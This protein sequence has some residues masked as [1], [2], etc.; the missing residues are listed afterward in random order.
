MTLEPREVTKKEEPTKEEPRPALPPPPKPSEYFPGYEAEKVGIG[1]GLYAAEKRVRQAFTSMEKVNLA[2]TPSPLTPQPTNPILRFL[3]GT[4]E[5]WMVSAAGGLINIEELEQRKVEAQAELDASTRELESLEW[6]L[7]VLNTLPGYLANQ[8]YTIT[9]ADDVL[10]LVANSTLS[11]VDR[12]WLERTLEKLEHLNNILPEDFTGTVDEAQEKVLNEI[13]SE[14]KLELRAVHN[15]T[16]DELERSFQP[17]AVDMPEGMTAEQVREVMGRIGL[18]E[19]LQKELDVYLRERASAW[20]KETDR[21]NLLRAGLLQPESPDLT[22][23]EFANLVFVQ[24]VMAGIEILDK[25]FDMLPRPLAASAIIGVHNMFKTDEDT[26]AG[27]MHETYQY[28]RSQ[29]ESSWDAYALALNDTE[30]NWVMRLG[31]ETVFDPTTY[32]GIGIAT[33]G[34][35]MVGRGLTRLGMRTAG[36]RIGPFVGAIENGFVEGSDALF[37]AGV[38]AVLSPIKGSFWLAGAG[39]QIPRTMT[40]LSRNFGRQASMNFKAVLDR[41]FPSVRN[42]KGLASGDIRDTAEA[43]IK[44]ALDRPAEGHDLMVKTGAELLEFGYLDANTAGKLLKGLVDETFDFDVIRL[45]RINNEVLNMFSGQSPKA[46]AG[47]I[48]SQMGLLQTDEALETTVTKLAVLKDSIVDGAMRAFKADAPNSQLIGMFDNLVNTRYENLASP[49]TTHMT[50]AGR[51]VSWVSRVADRVLHASQLISLERKVIMPFARWNLLFANFGPFNYLENMQRSFLGGAEV[52]YPKSYGGVAQTNRLFKGLTNAPYELQMAE[53]GVQRME[54]ALIDPKT[55]STAAFRNGR[56][57]F[58]TKS[59]KFRGKDIGKGI[60][61][62]GQEFK[63]TDMQAYND[64]WEQLTTIQRA[65]DYQ[66]HYM[67]SLQ[68]VAPDEMQD[69]A[70]SVLRRRAEIEQIGKFSP[71]DIKDIERSLIQDATVGPEEVAAHANLSTLE[72]E[73]R[74]ISKE[75]YKTLD[76]CTDVHRVTKA[77]I[78][79]EVLDGSIFTDI[80]GR[81]AAWTEHERELSLAS[82]T[83][84]ID[85]LQEEASQFARAYKGEATLLDDLTQNVRLGDVEQIA[86]PFDKAPITVD[87][88]EVGTITFH[89]GFTPDELVVYELNITTPG[90]LNRRFMQDMDLVIHNLAKERGASKI[91]IVPKESHKLLYESAGY[92]R[93]P[94]G[95]TKDV[96]QPPSHAPQNLDELLGDLENISG[97]QNAIDERIHDYRRLTEL[98]SHSLRPGKEVDDFHVGSNRLL[99]DF[100]EQSKEQMDSIVDELQKFMTE[101][102]TIYGPDGKPLPRLTLTDSQQGAVDGLAG[103]YRM[104]NANVIATRNRLAEVEARIPRTPPKQRNDR[105]WAQQRAEKAAIWDEHTVNSRRLRNLR[106]DSSRAFLTSVGKAPFLPDNIIPVAGELTPSHI[107]YLFGTTGDDVYRGLT[108]ISHHS[109]VRPREDFIDYVRNQAGAYA[110]K[111]EKNAVDLG[112]SDEAIGE[113]YDQL[114]R[115]LGFEPSMLTPDSPTVTQLDDIR[116]ELNRLHAT[117]RMDETDV[118]RWRQYVDGVEGD[119]RQTPMYRREVPETGEDIASR[120]GIRYEGLQTT[121]GAMLTFTD[122]ESG[123]TFLARD[124]EH[125]KARFAEV[126]KSFDLPEPVYPKAAAEDW[127][128]KKEQAMTRA[129]ELHELAYPTYDDANVIDETMRAIFPFWT[130]EAF[131]W[132]WMPRTWMRTP[133]TMTGLARYMDYSDGGYFPFPGTDLQIN[134]LRGSIWMGG[135]RRFFLKDFPEY[136]DAMPGMEFID[137]IGRAGFYPGI[138]IMAPIVMFGATAGGKPEL[139]EVLPTWARAGLSALRELSPEHIGKVIDI[140][141]PDRFRDF[142]T[143][144]TLGKWGY[145]ADEIQRKKSQQQALT[146]E[147]EK[148]WLRAEAEANGLKGLLMEETGL[149]RIRPQE[150]E[151]IRR[152]LRLAIEEAIGVPVAIQQQIDRM[153]P[154]TGKRLSDYYKLDIMQQKLLYE[155]EE[156]RRWQGIITPL[157]PSSWQNLENKIKDYYQTLEKNSTEARHTGVYRDGELIRPSIVDLNRQRVTGEI[158]PDQWKSMLGDIKSKQ[159]EAARVLGESPAY[160]GVPKTLEEREEWLRTKGVPTPTYSPDQELL[161]YYY[162][163]QPELKY[164][165]D[166]QRMELDFDT[167]YAKIDSLLESLDEHHR[168]RMLDRIQIDWTPMERLYW[169]VSREYLRP[170][171]N[172]R[173]IV[174]EQ[175]TDE[176]RQQIRRFEVARGKE[177]EALQEILGPDGEKLISGF[178]TRVREARQRLRYIDPELD[179]WSYFFGNTDS[180]I[181]ATAEVL[182]EDI[183]KQY[184]VESMVQ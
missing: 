20:A 11:E 28:Y 164:N 82:L 142:Q 102:P 67:K 97:M 133:G 37:K 156:F 56:I 138:H 72:L 125:A 119:L 1:Q 145:D 57:P 29:G 143:M 27:R 140:I 3:F 136:Y 55:G 183:A 114:W 51:N 163:I 158:G 17:F 161:W 75:L 132:R 68:E 73:R 99:N 48:L 58:V 95:Y 87:G 170:Y 19:E 116:Q 157:L 155:F 137:F 98:R 168:Q 43:C 169:T 105:F 117:V 26:M 182:Y 50:Q 34:A 8:N 103:V 107:A 52:M 127:W 171:R 130:Y 154:V 181:T 91:T 36:A 115:N 134:P 53:R 139:N 106:L 64:M 10:A 126:R 150:Y 109:T 147:E 74:Q 4:P 60:N 122:P 172:I 129:R 173:S 40:Q 146:P 152:E 144:L 135:M 18:D 54:M 66:V 128:A 151:T 46:T 166:S 176:Q 38:Q 84:Q 63:I 77:G 30:M 39:Y 180:F 65:Y 149:L 9:S 12:A 90:I 21:L 92:T 101:R 71:S 118:A 23:G 22:P 94:I 162:E 153:Y 2:A 76:K 24:P 159:A 108:R 49:I 165:W 113:V 111:F 78:R 175:Y 124:F 123:S 83:K 25:Y 79:D 15:L 88:G 45:S 110:N 33:A 120:L 121:N 167:Y 42:L 174:L 32:I 41:A 177:R 61:I 59:M 89:P 14:P 184:L 62:R 131:R 13:L 16:I 7:E 178:N 179:A 47:N 160:K 70:N 35:G 6:K 80:D 104:E 112:F 93:K 44:A 86:G 148:L 100:M 85:A 31:V 5:G 96:M 81:I 69:I 141:F